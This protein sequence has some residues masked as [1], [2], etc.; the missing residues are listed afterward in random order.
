M[1]FEI[2]NSNKQKKSINQNISSIDLGECENKIKEKYNI[3]ETEPLIILKV[4]SKNEDLTITYVQYEIYNPKTFEQLD[5]SICKDYPININFPL[6]LDPKIELLYQSLNESGYNLFNPND[7]FYN[8]ICTTF[9]TENN[10]DIII[11]DRRKDYYESN[12]NITL[13]QIGCIFQYY[14]ITTK[15][16]NCQ[17]EVQNKNITTNIKD[18]K[19]YTKEVLKNFL[20]T[21]KYS[22]FMVLKCYKLLLDISKLNKNIGFIIMTILLILSIIFIFIHYIISQ[23]KIFLFIKTIIKGM[24]FSDIKEQKNNKKKKNIDKSKDNGEE[25]NIVNIY[26]KKI[27]NR[28]DKLKKKSTINKNK[29]HPPPKKS[30][31]SN[32]KKNNNIYQIK[33]S[34]INNSDSNCKSDVVKKKNKSFSTSMVK[35][36]NNNKIKPLK[37]NSV[38]IYSKKRKMNYNDQELN[39]LEYIL[40]VEVDKRTYFQY[41]WSLLKKKH[42]FLFTF[43][44]TNDYNLISIKLS[45]FILSFSLYFT[46]NGFFFNDETMHKIYVNKG[47]LSFLYQIPQILYSTIITAIINVLLKQLSLSETTILSIKKEKDLLSATNKSKKISKCFQFKFLFFFILNTILNV[48]FWYFISC[49]CAVYINTQILLIKD[50]LYSFSSSMIYPFGLNLL[51]GMLRIPAL[52]AENKDKM[53]LYRISCLI[54]LI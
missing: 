36:K 15:R 41:Y 18:I 16:S 2:T 28:K 23:N 44:P 39:N 30:R 24:F 40:A 31:K 26:K 9:K 38:N 35:L 19:F 54:A 10:T 43:F 6:L 8:E 53:C 50:T 52:M 7:S 34:S 42:L 25:K 45:L 49:F 11:E 27:K 21:L 47:S 22:N 4:D 13:C 3:L 20:N 48:F 37:Y 32:T 46:I 51:P 1:I 14:N 17:C 12:A 29:K 33:L 5:L